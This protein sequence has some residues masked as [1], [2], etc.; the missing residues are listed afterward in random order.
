[1]W[2]IWTVFAAIAISTGCG[3]HSEEQGHGADVPD[4]ASYI[5]VEL[6]RVDTS[7]HSKTTF[8][9]RSQAD[10]FLRRAL[11]ASIEFISAEEFERLSRI[12]YRHFKTEA[13]ESGYWDLWEG[14]LAVRA[15]AFEKAQ[16]SFSSSVQKMLQNKDSASVGHTLN[17][18]GAT[19]IYLGD[20]VEANR[21]HVK[22]LKLY[23][24]LKDS[25]GMFATLR[26]IASVNYR[27]NNFE[28]AEKI[29]L[30]CLDYY[31]KQPSKI[32]LASTYL[33]FGEMY[34]IK[35]DI[36]QFRY[37]N[38]LA[39]KSFEDESYS[40]GIAQTY[41]NM[42]VSEMS[43]GNFQGAK[44]WLLKSKAL[45]DSTGDSL[46]TPIQ[47]YNIGVCEMETGNLNESEDLLLRS[48]AINEQRKMQGQ[49]TVRTFSRLAQIAERRNDFKLAS[50]Y[51][52]KKQAVSDSIFNLENKKAIDEIQIQYETQK[53][54]NEL[55]ASKLAEKHKENWIWIL[56]TIIIS[57]LSIILIT[58]L[59]LIT[60][61]RR[62][63][64]KR[65]LEERLQKAEFEK[66]Q[67]ELDFHKQQLTD[68]VSTLKE[69][70]Q[71][72]KTL[73]ENLS[74]RQH[75]T[76]LVDETS[77]DQPQPENI[78]SL[79]GFKILT[80]DDWMRFKKY[81]DNVYPGIIQKLRESYPDITAA[82]QRLFMLIRLNSDSREISQ[83]LGISMDSVR[84][85]KYRLKKKLELSEEA[86]L[87]EF[88]KKF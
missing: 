26:E 68:Y 74:Q 39:L 49:I 73:E 6:A 29:L 79:F 28:K 18:L 17:W 24:S 78:E 20:F 16:K 85:T 19:Q 61:N 7:L 62:K 46:Q 80:E 27:Q 83:M 3:Q 63:E 82:E 33:T 12:Y 86:S 51:L 60:R 34:Q 77:T 69:K 10:S 8:E 54:E 32:A 31:K 45:T 76:V 13:E 84:K 71:Q 23:E 81:F 21:T 50:A 42:A 25:A 88:V 70:S 1:M 65:K 30:G 53:K 59:L 4:S 35:G 87:D 64:E 56:T 55:Q 44:S 15:G 66:V 52:K 41:N 36:S 5:I 67:H 58:G 72:I 43:T 9:S 2:R 75:N 37:Y 40:E 22:A 57:I 47:L 38:L 14:E 48:L 11:S